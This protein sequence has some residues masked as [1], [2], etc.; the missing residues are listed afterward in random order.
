[1]VTSRFFFRVEFKIS[2]VSAGIER[3]VAQAG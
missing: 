2:V 1:M 3:L